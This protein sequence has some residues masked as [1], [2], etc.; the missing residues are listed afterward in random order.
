ME[1]KKSNIYTDELVVKCTC[2]GKNILQDIGMSMIQIVTDDNDNIIKFNPCC[3]GKCEKSLRSSVPQNCSSIC[4]ELSTFTNP[5]LYLK[6]SMRTYNKMYEGKK[7]I[8][9]QAF[10]NFNNTLINMAPYVMRDMTEDEKQTVI[11]GNSFL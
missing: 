4:K 10:E 11:L 3:K 7:F 1:F 9:K 2:C 8:D 5:H 6:Y